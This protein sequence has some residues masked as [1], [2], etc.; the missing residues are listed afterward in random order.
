MESVKGITKEFSC[1]KHPREKI[2]RVS[3]IDSI[4]ALYCIECVLAI[5]DKQIK[6][7]VLPIKEFIQHTATYFEKLTRQAA[8]LKGDPS[9]DLLAALS[10]EDEVVVG[11]SAQ[12]EAEKFKV[13][14]SFGELIQSFT[15]LCNK[16][17][18]ELLNDLDTQ[19]ST[20]RNNYRY[21]KDKISKYYGKETAKEIPAFN[22]ESGIVS[23]INKC[24]TT[25]DLEALIE[26]IKS[27]MT[28]VKHLYGLSGKNGGISDILKELRNSIKTQAE[29]PP[30]TPFSDHMELQKLTEKIQ[31]TLKDLVKGACF[32]ENEIAPFPT[33]DLTPIMDSKI[34]KKSSDIGMIRNWLSSDPFSITFKLLLRGTRDGFLASTF[35]K[36][37]DNKKNTLVLVKTD[38]GKV[39]GGFTELDWSFINNYKKQSSSFL[40]SV[41][42]K[43]KFPLKD[44]SFHQYSI[45]Y[46]NNSL[47]VFGGGFDLHL[48]DRCNE[49]WISTSNF[50]HSYDPGKFAGSDVR[51]TLTGG[52]NFKVLEYEVFQVKGYK[53]NSQK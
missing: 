24:E 6:E 39:C 8:T 53:R 52:S 48:A 50:G 29:K 44:E 17:K 13:E 47:A 15:N 22:T 3:S 27:E 25:A 32:I 43:A 7:A 5:E 38:F 41:D 51:N 45:A 21:L 26:K 36:K 2:Q 31:N 4:N 14:I 49:N 37:C 18:H 10:S 20:F 19:F 34:V 12:I 1:R 42:H 40:F 28:E 11:V 16:A 23:A 9:K 33:L 46:L 30:K 35:H